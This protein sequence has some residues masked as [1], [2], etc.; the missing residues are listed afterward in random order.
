MKDI[1]IKRLQDENEL[2]R[3]RCS[4]FRQNHQLI[5]LNNM[6]A[7]MTQ[8]YLVFHLQYVDDK[9][10]DAVTSIIEDID[11]IIQNGD[12]EACYRI[13]KPAK[14]RPLKKTIVRFV[15]RKYCQKT[16]INRNEVKRST[17]SVK[18]I[19]FHKQQFNQSKR[20]NRILW[21]KVKAEWRN[22]FLLHQESNCS[23]KKT[24]VFESTSSI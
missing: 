21:E 20:V 24:L 4:K 19:N 18:I 22:L 6:E 13:G 23:H 17:T 16:L 2:L 15:D 11:V 1:I 3:S 9:S 5:K 7:G 12:M 8:L 14:K 10:E